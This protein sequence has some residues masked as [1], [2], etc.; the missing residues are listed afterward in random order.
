MAKFSDKV[1]CF[2]PTPSDG[3]VVMVIPHS[4]RCWGS[5]RAGTKTN[6]GT[7][8]SWSTFYV[9]VQWN[10]GIQVHIN[11][12]LLIE[13]RGS[14]NHVAVLGKLAI[15]HL[16]QDKMV[17][18]IRR[19]LTLIKCSQTLLFRCSATKSGQPQRFSAIPGPR[20]T[21][22]NMLENAYNGGSENVVETYRRRFERW[23]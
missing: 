14:S 22:S 12:H 7:R 6:A 2:L 23:V 16:M 19:S 18:S 1:R 15:F 13:R 4:G 20:G 3:P 5:A 9:L 10:P 17:L 8:H 21:L 11:R